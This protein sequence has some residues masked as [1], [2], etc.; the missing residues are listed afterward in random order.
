MTVESS[1]LEPD[2]YS[3]KGIAILDNDGNRIFAKYYNETFSS[4]KDQKAFERNLFNKT[5]RANGEV[6]MLDGF[7]CIYRNSVDLFFYIMGN[8]NENG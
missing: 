5:H 8:S 2:L 1:L 6:I 7:T 3:V 4:V